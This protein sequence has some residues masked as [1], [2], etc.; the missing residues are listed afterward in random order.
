[1]AVEMAPRND[2]LCMV[3]AEQGPPPVG[4]DSV[5]PKNRLVTVPA[6][7]VGKVGRACQSVVVS[8]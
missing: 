2:G 3:D 1:M 4:E 5:G 6:C 7:Q 8:A